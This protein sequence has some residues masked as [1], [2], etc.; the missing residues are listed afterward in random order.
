MCEIMFFSENIGHMLAER[1]ILVS[2]DPEFRKFSGR[3]LCARGPKQAS[4]RL[5]PRTHGRAGV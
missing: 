3:R 4:A 5:R 1:E 2:E